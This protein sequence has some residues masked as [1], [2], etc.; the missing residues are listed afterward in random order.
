VR[1]IAASEY[2]TRYSIVSTKYIIMRAREFTINVPITISINGDE[3][4]VISAGDQENPKDNTELQQNPVMVSPLQQQ[5]EL[6]KASLGKS[7]PVIDKI[8][9]DH[10]EMGSENAETPIEVGSPE[11]AIPSNTDSE[12]L[13]RIKSLAS[14]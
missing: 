8:T 1:E 4:P 9:Q 14:R 12:L 6:A 2:Y 3:D 7:S 10:P 11:T 13:K 5:V